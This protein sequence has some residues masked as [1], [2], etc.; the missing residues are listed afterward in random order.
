MV[1]MV[2]FYNA[3]LNPYPNYIQMVLRWCKL[4]WHGVVTLC[5]A[6]HLLRGLPFPARRPRPRHGEAD[7][8]G[9]RFVAGLAQ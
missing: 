1:L 5:R 7:G 6:P 4:A 3:H 8:V 2:S 9:L